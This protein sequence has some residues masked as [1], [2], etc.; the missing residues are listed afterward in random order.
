MYYAFRLTVAERAEVA[1]LVAEVQQGKCFTERALRLR[2]IWHRHSLGEYICATC[3][4]SMN[5]M[6]EQFAAW[7]KTYQDER[8]D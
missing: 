6:F 2:E 7:A 4:H 3:N 5:A 1:R 8:K